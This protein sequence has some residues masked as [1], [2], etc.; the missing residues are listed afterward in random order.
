LNAVVLAVEQPQ[1]EAEVQFTLH[2]VSR[3]INSTAS[4]AVW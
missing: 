3:K 1:L 4:V 2:W